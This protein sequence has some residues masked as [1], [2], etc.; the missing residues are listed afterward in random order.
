MPALD[1]NVLIRYLVQD[2]EAQ[3]ATARKLIRKCV[4]EG[5]T[6]FVPV[7]VTLELEWVLRASF[8]YAKDDV[9]AALSSLFSA[10]ELTFESEQALEVALQLYRGGS[11]DFADCLHIALAA[12]AGELPLWTFDK[13]A[14]K[15]NGAR[16]PGSQ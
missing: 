3:L 15:V 14:A 9:M 8:E 6:L 4:S 1:T 16:L 10:A 2:D 11:A 5:L 13:R 7:T 12:Q